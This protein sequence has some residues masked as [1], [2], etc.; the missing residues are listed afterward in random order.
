MSMICLPLPK[1]FVD[2]LV[3]TISIAYV[4]DGVTHIG[5]VPPIYVPEYHEN[6]Q[7]VLCQKTMK[8]G[9]HSS[10]FDEI[11]NQKKKC[12]V[13]PHSQW[14]KK[15]SRKEKEYDFSSAPRG[16]LM[17]KPVDLLSIFFT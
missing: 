8:M 6:C 5:E 13:L 3:T 4:R 15:F 1:R 11:A 2:N 9:K 7:R 14:C 17:E 10:K 12:N 16:G